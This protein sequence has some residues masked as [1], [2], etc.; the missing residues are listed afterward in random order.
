MSEEKKPEPQVIRVQALD[1]VSCVDSAT[2][3]VENLR[4]TA[5]S[6]IDD[7]ERVLSSNISEGLRAEIEQ[8]VIIEVMRRALKLSDQ[9]WFVAAWQL[10]PTRHTGPGPQ[11]RS[12]FE[13]FW[14]CHEYERL[15]REKGISQ[16]EF[17]AYLKKTSQIDISRTTFN[18]YYRQYKDAGLSK[19]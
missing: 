4:D 13:R 8:R 1:I 2:V 18:Y 14:I 15:K 17:L 11:G 10:E 16:E 6:A 7:I 19:R 5:I 3:T 12:Y 9:E